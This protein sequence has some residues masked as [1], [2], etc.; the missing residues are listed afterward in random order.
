M[1][2]DDQKKKFFFNNFVQLQLFNYPT[3]QL[4]NDYPNLTVQLSNCSTTLTFQLFYFSTVLL[5]NCL[6][7]QLVY[8]PNVQLSTVIGKTGFFF[9]A[10][11]LRK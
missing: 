3:V 4:F 1:W 9:F 10:R 8:F 6:T 11:H 7:L 5:F 2:Y